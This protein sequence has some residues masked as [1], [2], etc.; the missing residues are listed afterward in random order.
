MIL[1]AYD[2]VLAFQRLCLPQE[3]QHW[4]IA[5]LRRELCWL[6]AEWVT[7]GNRLYLRLPA[8]YPRPDLFRKVQ[9]AAS[10]VQPLI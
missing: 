5:T 3:V 2:L 9:A 1:R 6:P 8:R 7:R 10:M 4:N